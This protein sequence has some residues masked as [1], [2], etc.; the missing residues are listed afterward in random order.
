MIEFQNEVSCD[1]AILAIPEVTRAN[2]YFNFSGRTGGLGGR[3]THQPQVC[4]TVLLQIQT[5]S[6]GKPPTPSASD[7]SWGLDQY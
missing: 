7:L 4:S 1:L 3:D 5:G 6:F 2:L